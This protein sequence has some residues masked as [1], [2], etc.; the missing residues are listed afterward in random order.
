MVLRSVREADILIDDDDDDLR[1][2]VAEV[3]ELR[4]FITGVA[5]NDGRD[6]RSR[7]A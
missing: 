5:N 6:R 1:S 2:T 4:G 7:S 3:L